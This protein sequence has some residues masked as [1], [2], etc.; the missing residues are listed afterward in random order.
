ML[1]Q[2]QH[3]AR[4]RFSIL[5]NARN[6]DK[7]VARGAY[8]DIWTSARS[9]IRNILQRFAHQPLAYIEYDL[10]DLWYTII[11]AATI[12]PADEPAQDKLV[13]EVV[14]AR[15]LGSLGSRAK[16]ADGEIWSGLPFLVEDVTVAWREKF[17]HLQ[18]DRKL[19]LAAFTARLVAVGVRAP[20]LGLCALFVLRETL[21]TPRPLTVG[22]DSER[23]TSVAELLPAAVAWFRFAGHRLAVF[24]GGNG[25][26]PLTGEEGEL[27]AVG[28]LAREAGVLNPGFSDKRWNFWLQRLEALSCVDDENIK[29]EGRRG[30]NSMTMWSKY[31]GLVAE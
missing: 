18:S 3:Q 11:Q 22:D 21:E 24:S 31:T 14:L 30:K 19:N 12:T 8:D 17:M 20:E 10:H 23:D 5:V 4:Q 13:T 28:Q 26:E 1:T 25:S 27:T 15:E 6:I 9:S 2:E 16:T 29:E 7:E